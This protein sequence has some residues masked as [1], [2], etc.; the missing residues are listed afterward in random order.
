MATCEGERGKKRVLFAVLTLCS[1]LT[2]QH[3]ACAR[4]MVAI[5]VSGPA[6]VPLSFIRV[7]THLSHVPYL[8]ITAGVGVG[9]MV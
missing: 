3:A 5:S 4:H 8:Y 7:E 1:G 9:T 6:D 2:G